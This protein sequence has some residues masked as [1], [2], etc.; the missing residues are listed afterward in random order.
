LLFSWQI[1]LALADQRSKRRVISQVR[2]YA[3]EKNC[4]LIE[5]TLKGICRSIEF[6]ARFFGLSSGTISEMYM[7]ATI[8]GRGEL[9]ARL[10]K[11]LSPVTFSLIQRAVPL[12]GRLN[13][14]EKVFA[15]VLTNVTNGEEKARKEFKKGDIAFMPSG[16]MICFFMQDTRS[17]KPM[18]P[19][20]VITSGMEVLEAGKRGDYLEIRSI[21]SSSNI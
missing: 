18:N 13:F 19:L 9:S 3:S 4:S 1:N 16:S 10:Y 11:H 8:P 17:Y 7:K 14:Y 15:Y 2:P 20:G 6:V 5:E 21:D 12:T